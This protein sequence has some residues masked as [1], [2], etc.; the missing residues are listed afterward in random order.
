MTNIEYYNFFRKMDKEI[1]TQLQETAEIVK[2]GYRCI[3]SCVLHASVAA[4]HKSVKLCN[5]RIGGI[6]NYDLRSHFWQQK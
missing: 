5:G 2:Q 6:C 1:D 3:A 4:N